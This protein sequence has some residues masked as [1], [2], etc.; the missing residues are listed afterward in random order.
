MEHRTAED[1]DK[2]K[3]TFFKKHNFD[4]HVF[5]SNNENNS[6]IK[7]YTFTDGAEFYERFAY[8]EEDMPVEVEVHG[9]IFN[10]KVTVKYYTTE[11]WSSEFSSRFVWEKGE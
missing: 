9:L 11:Y 8:V 5:T 10:K 7:M 3:Q 1:F 6:Y 2:E 4:Y